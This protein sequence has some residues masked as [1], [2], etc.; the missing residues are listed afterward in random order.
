MEQKMYAKNLDWQ[1]DQDDHDEPETAAQS[2][3][4]SDLVTENILSPGSS[5]RRNLSVIGQ[6]LFFKGDLSAEEDL[7]IQ[8]TVVGSITHQ[9]QNLTIGAHGDVQADIVAQHVI[10]QGKVRGDVRASESIIVEASARVE[11]NLYA[12][13]IGLREGA[14]FKGGI[15]MDADSWN[16]PKAPKHESGPKSTTTQTSQPS[17]SETTASESAS[18]SAPGDSPATGSSKRRGGAAKKG[19]SSK[20]TAENKQPDPA[21]E[22]DG[23]L[24]E[25]KVDTLLD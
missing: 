20:K 10:I 9:A 14:K 19:S 18:A 17:A 6:T 7:L 4:S 22:S 2:A 1:K 5:E 11:G 13:C 15:D 21:A 23:E 8:G 12:P 3:Q 24:S 16:P 25:E